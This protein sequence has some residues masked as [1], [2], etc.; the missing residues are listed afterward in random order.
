MKDIVFDLGGVLI[1]WNPRYLYKKIFSSP[2]EMEHFLTHICHSAW[3]AQMDAG[4]PFKEA[5]KERQEKFPQYAPQIAAYFTRWEE[6]LGGSIEETVS[7]LKDLKCLGARIYALTNW[8]AETL[9][10]AL[11]R[12]DFFKLFDGMTVSGQVK[13]AKP[14][15]AIFKR[16]LADFKLQATNCIFIDD[17]ADNIRTAGQLGFTAVRF[18]SAVELKKELQRLGVG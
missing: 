9:P 18:T 17:N 6:M 1:D 14:D 11:A 4:I 3:N 5:I 8:S 10:Y 7:V 16:L 12:Y 13:L 15:P 2:A